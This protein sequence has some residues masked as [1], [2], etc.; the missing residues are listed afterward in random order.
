MRPDETQHGCNSGCRRRHPGLRATPNGS[1]GGGVRGRE[2]RPRNGRHGRRD[3]GSSAWPRAFRQRRGP[4]SHRIRRRP[5]LATQSAPGQRGA[6]GLGIHAK[7]LGGAFGGLG[8]GRFRRRWHLERTGDRLAGRQAHCRLA[9]CGRL[10][11]QAG[12]HRA[13]PSPTPAA[14]RLRKHR[15]GARVG[16]PAAPCRCIRRSQKPRP[17]SA[18]GAGSTSRPRWRAKPGA[19]H[20]PALRHVHR[21]V[22]TGTTTGRAGQGSAPLESASSSAHRR[23][24]DV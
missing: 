14:A 12:R 23:L 17:L 9:G 5:R 2:L 3:A 6:H 16:G 15:R 18:H 20:P 11:R 1:A 4:R 7:P 21:E 10:E 22:R 8:G 13:R 19:P 24:G